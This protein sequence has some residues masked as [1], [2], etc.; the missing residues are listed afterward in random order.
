MEIHTIIEKNSLIFVLNGNS[1]IKPGKNP[2]V[3]IQTK[4]M[5]IASKNTLIINISS[6]PYYLIKKSLH[7]S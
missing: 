7:L 5:T 2:I 1:Y 3:F 4:R 6:K